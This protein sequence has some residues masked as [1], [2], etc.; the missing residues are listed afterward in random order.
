MA[1]APDEPSPGDLAFEHEGVPFLIARHDAARLGG[2][3]VDWLGFLLA[4]PAACRA[5]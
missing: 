2:V 3:R 5:G 1:L 4:R